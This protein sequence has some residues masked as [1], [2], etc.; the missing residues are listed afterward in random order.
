[1]IR[2]DREYQCT[3]ER[4]AD[5]T[6]QIKSVTQQMSPEGFD[7]DDIELATSGTKILMKELIWERDFYDR[8]RTEGLSAI[9]DYPPEERGK[10]LIAIRIARGMKQRELADALGVNEAQ[11]S[12]DEKQEYRGI[13][14]ERYARVLAALGVEEH[15]AGYIVREPMTVHMPTV[16]YQAA[17]F[18]AADPTQLELKA[19]KG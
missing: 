6:G 11:M 15:I 9:P 18:I 16:E 19:S 14:Q 1:M 10:V 7:R 3:V 12:R 5:F 13:T 2:N 17:S 8:L 4:I